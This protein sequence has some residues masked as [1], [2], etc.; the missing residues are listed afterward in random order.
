MTYTPMVN[1]RASFDPMG[2]DWGYIL[3][4]VPGPEWRGMVPVNLRPCTW[5]YQL[6]TDRHGRNAYGCAR[7]APDW[8]LYAWSGQYVLAEWEPAA[9]H[10]VKCRMRLERRY[11]P[12]G[13]VSDW[14][15]NPFAGEGNDR[16]QVCEWAVQ[17]TLNLLAG[18]AEVDVVRPVPWRG[19]AP[20]PSVPDDV[21]AEA[22]HKAG[23]MLAFFRT[24]CGRWRTGDLE[25]PQVARGLRRETGA[26]G[27]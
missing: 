26:H 22:A 25:R 21:R 20:A 1:D 15:S 13:E 17:I 8:C 14:P 2:E 16:W 3:D 27:E 23:K 4:E 18:T 6:N 9:E 12:A 24:E 19:M 11:A 7:L 5:P 10:T